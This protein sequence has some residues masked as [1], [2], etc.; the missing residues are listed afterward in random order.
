MRLGVIEG[1]HLYAD[2]WVPSRQVVEFLEPYGL[3]LEGALSSSDK[4]R[5]VADFMAQK[6]G[7]AAPHLHRAFDI[8]IRHAATHDNC[9]VWHE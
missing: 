9:P 5:S 2:C 6:T 4:A 7:V 3:E 1:E 8:P